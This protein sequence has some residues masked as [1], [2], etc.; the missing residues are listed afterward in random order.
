MSAAWSKS[1]SLLSL[2]VLITFLYLCTFATCTPDEP[3][4]KRQAPTSPLVDFQVS[5]PILT[6]SGQSDQYGCIHTMLLMEYEFANSYGAPFVGESSGFPYHTISLTAIRP[7]HT[8]T[9]QLQSSHHE[10]Y[11]HV[12]RTAI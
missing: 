3:I 5:Q 10:L 11:S 4:P 12:T 9:V 1:Q 8:A 7:L 6:P 2:Y